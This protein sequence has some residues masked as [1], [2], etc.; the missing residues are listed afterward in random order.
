[1]TREEI[2]RP[3]TTHNLTMRPRTRGIRKSYAEPKIGLDDDDEPIVAPDND[4]DGDFGE[5][6][7]QGQQ[8][9]DEDDQDDNDEDDDD[10]NSEVEADGVGDKDAVVSSTPKRQR[11]GAGMTQSRKSFHEIPHYPLETRIVTR[12][13]AGPLMRYARYSALRDSMYGPEYQRIKIIWD[14]EKRWQ[15][16]SVLPPAFP[17]SQRQG[18]V[19][20]PWVSSTYESDQERRVFQWYDDYQVNSPEIQRTRVILPKHGEQ[21]VSQADGDLV[22]LVG[23]CHAQKQYRLSPGSAIPISQSGL[24]AD[25]PED[26]E[27]EK[28]AAA[29]WILDVGGIPLSLAWA[30]STRKDAQV[31]A[32]ASVPF[33]DQEPRQHDNKENGEEPPDK[34][35]GFIQFWEFDADSGSHGLAA[36]SKRLPVHILTRCFD[37]GR[38]KR[39]EWCPVPMDNSELYGLL[40]ILCGDGLA[41]VIDVKRVIDRGAA[42]KYGWSFPLQATYAQA[43]TN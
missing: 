17:P 33:S 40:A 5:Q 22:A 1:M 43:C 10:D 34:S 29:G 42:P 4:E 28:S 16:F 23:P 13:Y 30:P 18:V 20:S 11:N 36:P 38:V 31:L 39:L 35:A 7:A 26:V 21:L 19:P 32:I 27:N 14:L 12:V 24:R 41:R 3:T 6:D 25:D 8:N 2:H 37:W 15:D 9:Q